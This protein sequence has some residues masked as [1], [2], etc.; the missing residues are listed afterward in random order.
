M[1]AISRWLC[2]LI[3]TRATGNVNVPP[4]SVGQSGTEAESMLMT[5]PPAAMA[6]R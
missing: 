2:C 5:M 1:L 3:A 4:Y 6:G